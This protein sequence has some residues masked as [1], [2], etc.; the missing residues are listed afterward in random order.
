MQFSLVQLLVLGALGTTALAASSS[1]APSPTQSALPPSAIDVGRVQVNR[2]VAFIAEQFHEKGIGGAVDVVV[3]LANSAVVWIK[4]IV[5]EDKEIRNK[6]TH[7]LVVRLA[8]NDTHVPRLNWVVTK[9]RFTMDGRGKYCV[10]SEERFERKIFPDI[11][12][13]V[14]GCEEGTFTMWGDGGFLN[15]AYIPGDAPRVYPSKG[16]TKLEF[17]RRG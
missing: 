1:P 11:T 10:E 6:W 12:Y 3:D 5:Q 7:D 16:V 4:G 14:L 15:Y 17:K 9:N 8:S 13:S 2:H